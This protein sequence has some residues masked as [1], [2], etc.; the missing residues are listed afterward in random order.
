VYFSSDYIFDGLAGPYKEDDPANPIC[1]YGRQKV[2]AEHYI[3]LNAQD[4]LIIR[5]TVVYG[6]E[7]Q[8]K[9]FI[10]RLLNTLRAGQRLP[11]PLD[12]IGN[13]TYAPNLSEATIK[14]SL[15]GARGVYH[16]VGPERVNRY[17][18][19]REAAKVFKLDES[20]LQP[21]TTPE[22]QQIAPRPLN[23]GMAIDK[24]TAVLNFPLLDYKTGLAIMAEQERV[25]P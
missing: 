10:Y 25:T 3:S 4:Y 22:L 15:T 2:I 19:A 1:E 7:H 8:G 21:V 11:V 17:E 16:I 20:L 24:V 12:Q 5:T 9:N 23:L 18:F 13:P 14:L 6:W